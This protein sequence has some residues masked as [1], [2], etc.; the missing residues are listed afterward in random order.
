MPGEAS[1]RQRVPD[2]Q[3]F[4]AGEHL[5]FCS[6]G[7][8]EASSGSI[9]PIDC[10]ES[11]G[12]IVR[13]DTHY[14]IWF[15]RRAKD[16][17]IR[18]MERDDTAYPTRR[19]ANYVLSDRRQ[20]WKAGQVLQCID[21]AF[22]QPMPEEMV[23]RGMPFG[24]MYVSIEQLADQAKSIRPAVKHVKAMKQRDELDATGRIK[25][26]ETIKAEFGERLADV[27]TELARLRQ[28]N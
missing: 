26:L 11:L 23:D 8:A 3:S 24:P 16:G 9:Y 10:L 18:S 6:L 12:T 28:Q 4:E 21:G 5:T 13:M 17:T 2:L 19:K 14:H 1:P 22:C 7:N 27:D 20:Y 15:Y 25:S